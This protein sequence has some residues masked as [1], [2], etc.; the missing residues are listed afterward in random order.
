MSARQPF[1][2][3]QNERFKNSPGT[4]LLSIGTKPSLAFIISDNVTMEKFISTIPE[5]LNVSNSKLRVP[6]K[7]LKFVAYTTGFLREVLSAINCRENFTVQSSYLKYAHA[8]SEKGASHENLRI[9]ELGYWPFPESALHL[10]K[11]G[12][13]H[14][15]FHQ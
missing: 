9:Q 14:K 1:L 15:S 8:R 7:L 5:E 11:H 4:A 10:L 3:Y 13:G 2:R 6:K 12:Q